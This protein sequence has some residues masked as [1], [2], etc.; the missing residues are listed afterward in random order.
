[1]SERGVD[2]IKSG[3]ALKQGFLV[4]GSDDYTGEIHLI[5]IDFP[6][7]FPEEVLD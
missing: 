7:E 5:D 6:R 1:M 3:S 2:Y 4:D